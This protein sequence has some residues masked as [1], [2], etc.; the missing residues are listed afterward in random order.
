MCLN[1]G[2]IV[3]LLDTTSTAV[4][5]IICERQRG[6]I[7]RYLTSWGRIEASDCLIACPGHNRLMNRLHLP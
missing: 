5:G 2:T 7:Y 3:H 4:A 1:R 6:P